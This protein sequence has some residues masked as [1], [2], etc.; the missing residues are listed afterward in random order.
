M[1]ER[2]SGE[3]ALTLVTSSC[4]WHFSSEDTLLSRTGNLHWC[5]HTSGPL[6]SCASGFHTHWHLNTKAQQPRES[7][8]QWVLTSLNIPLNWQNDLWTL[9]CA[10]AA[11]SGEVIPGWTEAVEAAGSVYTLI[12]AETT[13][14]TERK[15]TTL[16]DIWN[17]HRMVRGRSSTNQLFKHKYLQ[18]H[19]CRCCCRGRIW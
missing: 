11:V 8:P 16:I 4:T 12:D 1:W 10:A 17:T 19:L 7:P 14:L 3:C 2:D 6:C 18:F 9:T 15:Q 13:G 5:W